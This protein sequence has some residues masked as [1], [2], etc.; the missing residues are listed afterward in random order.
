MWIKLVQI[1]LSIVWAAHMQIKLL[2]VKL[3]FLIL[4]LL[5]SSLTYAH[6][7]ELAIMMVYQQN[8]KTLLVVKSSL[9]AFEGEVDYIFGKNAYKSPE[10]FQSL[11]I[12]HFQRNCSVV[13]DG[14]TIRFNNPNVILGHETTLIT[15]LSNVPARF[16]SIDILNNMFGDIPANMCE[17]I[18]TFNGLPQKQYI[19]DNGN[20]HVVRFKIDQG[21]WVIDNPSKVF[22]FGAILFISMLL[23]MVI[24]LLLFKGYKGKIQLKY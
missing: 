4:F 22:S 9:T 21:K 6:G 23:F 8:D 20:N 15:E 16:N 13:F 2:T 7:P 19:L 17:V 12:R 10:E 3:R 24:A 14:D 5:S 18:L 11:V 1:T